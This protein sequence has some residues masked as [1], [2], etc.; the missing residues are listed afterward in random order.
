M[1]SELQLCT[2]CKQYFELVYDDYE[3]VITQTYCK[4]PPQKINLDEV[5][6]E[7]EGGMKQ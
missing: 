4:C 5:I 6:K 1:Q 3:N 2:I 7:I